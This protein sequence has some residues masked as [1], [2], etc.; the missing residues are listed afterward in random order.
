MPDGNNSRELVP[1]AQAQGSNSSGF[2]Q[3]GA[4]DW[5]ALGQTTFTASV[6]ILGR[7][8]S[9]G[10]EPLT[11]AIGQAICSRIPLG[12]HGEN[13]LKQAMAK[14][15]ACSSFGDVVWF[16]VGVRHVLRTLVQT[17]QGCSL[18]AL[19]AALNEGHNR[20]TSALIIYEIARLCGSPQDISPSFS[21]WEALIKASSSVFAGSTFGLRLH[22]MLKLGGYTQS[23][24][25]MIYPGHPKDLA[26]VILAVGSVVSGDTREIR[27]RGGP[28]CCWIAAFA[29]Y[30]LGLNVTMRLQ[31]GSL[32]FSN[33]DTR[34]GSAQ[35]SVDFASALPSEGLSCVGRVFY[36]RHGS[37]FIRQSF[38]DPVV[39]DSYLGGRVEFRTMLQETFGGKIVALLCPQPQFWLPGVDYL[40]GEKIDDFFVRLYVAGAVAFVSFTAEKCRYQDTTDFLRCA[41]SWIPELRLN[42]VKLLQAARHFDNVS[43]DRQEIA[44]MYSTA[45]AAIRSRCTCKK[46]V[47]LEKEAF[48]LGKPTDLTSKNKSYCLGRLADLLLHLS[49]LFGRLR[50]HGSLSPTRVGLLRLYEHL[51]KFSTGVLD[52]DAYKSN[53][54]QG[55]RKSDLSNL[56]RLLSADGLTERSLNS[57]LSSYITL[58]SSQKPRIQLASSPSAMSDGMIYCFMDTVQCLSDRYEKASMI[59]VGAGSIQVGNRLHDRIFDEVNTDIAATAGYAAYDVAFPSTVSTALTMDT[60][61]DDLHLQA[62][63]DQSIHLS[64]WYQAS[65]K[66]GRLLVSPG[67]FVKQ[68]S[69]AIEYRFEDF[70]TFP[71][72]P[73]KDANQAECSIVF[74]EGDLRNISATGLVVR[75]HV[76]NVLG[77]CFALSTSGSRVALID[78]DQDL[79]TLYRALKKWQVGFVTHPFHIIVI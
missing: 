73:L 24:E 26:E 66:S 19:C 11:V 75:P 38:H 4:V 30:V 69:Q 15:Q 12:V 28:T 42:E 72:L 78:S 8:S 16:G 71:G 31:D 34:E 44:Q 58:F 41:F 3:Q 74:G 37:D 67:S 22:Q 79:E 46:C 48:S 43:P 29:D 20:S 68:L 62:V 21:Q 59:H 32:V 49:F 47:T 57:Q 77:R 52:L 70:K 18:V 6:A 25:T 33:F 45:K 36:I 35:I 61:T 56:Q 2:V 14:L 9:A 7:L 40:S 54:T 17:S 53:P 23:P 1:T 27:V 60:T 64:F 63:V 55:A 39:G 10:I 50:L 13:V 76:G 65:C 5:V 51:T